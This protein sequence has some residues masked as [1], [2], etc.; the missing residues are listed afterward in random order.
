MILLWHMHR[1][2][3]LSV[4]AANLHVAGDACVLKRT[5]SS[6]IYACTGIWWFQGCGGLG[7]IPLLGRMG[8]LSIGWVPCCGMSL[9]LVG[10]GFLVFVAAVIHCALT[11]SE[12]GSAAQ[13]YEG[14]ST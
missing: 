8:V 11:A 4:V 1:L 3:Q 5:S 2:F 13:L 14:S 9:Y 6:V 10:S 12:Q 7:L